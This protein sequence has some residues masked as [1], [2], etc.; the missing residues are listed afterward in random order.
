MEDLSGLDRLDRWLNAML[1]LAAAA[2]MAYWE[3]RYRKRA[4]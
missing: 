4:T 3:T 1:P 2:V